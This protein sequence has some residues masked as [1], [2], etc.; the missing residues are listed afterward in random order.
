MRTFFHLQ[1]SNCIFTSKKKYFYYYFS[2]VAMCMWV[3][4]S[5]RIMVVVLSMEHLKIDKTHS[6]HYVSYELPQQTSST[7]RYTV[8]RKKNVVF[9]FSALTLSDTRGDKCHLQNQPFWG[10]VNPIF[11]M[12]NFRGSRGISRCLNFREKFRTFFFQKVSFRLLGQ[13]FRI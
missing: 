5:I 9:L 8:K 1:H 4:S 12:K 6:R 2:C 10:E 7:R 11:T 3:E 13:I